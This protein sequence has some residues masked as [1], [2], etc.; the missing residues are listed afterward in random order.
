[1]S[2]KISLWKETR[3]ALHSSRYSWPRIHVLCSC[4]GACIGIDTYSWVRVSLCFHVEVPWVDELAGLDESPRQLHSSKK[5][6]QQDKTQATEAKKN[7]KDSLP[8]HFLF[9]LSG[10][11]VFDV[12]VPS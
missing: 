7:G 4:T 6:S 5:V 1:M 8:L 12:E 11:F 3:P 9:L 10:F 2:L